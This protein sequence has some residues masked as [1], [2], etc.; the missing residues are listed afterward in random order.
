MRVG[1]IDADLI[2][3]KKHRF[4]NLV[5]EKI[6]AYWKEKG[7]EVELKLDYEDLDSYDH[8]Y[9]SKVFTDTPFPKNI[10]ETDQI[11][12]GGTGFYF[13][14]APNLPDEIE[15]HMPDYH[16]YDEW[17]NKQIESGKKRNDF[18]YYLDYSIGFTSRGCFR[19]CEFCVNR[20]YKKV[21]LHSPLR[22]F[23]DLSR[24][25]ICLLDDNILGSPHW[26]EIF[27]ELQAT[28]K[29]FQYKQGMDERLLTDE[30][31]EVLFKS[32][33]DG[34]YI[35]AFDNVADYELI[36]KKLQLLRKYT[37]KIPKFYVFCGFDREDKWNDE[38]WKQDLWDLWKR[39]E[40]LMKYLCLPYI[41]RFN[42]Y[43]ESPYK[44]TYINLAAW[45]NQPSAFKKKSYR[46]FVEY[47]QSRHQ[48]ECSET[49]YLKQIERD[50]PELAERYFDMKFMD[51]V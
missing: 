31:C 36:E 17:A 7:A 32:K 43:E 13:D 4:P 45:C 5:S 24:K 16:L 20:N 35:F 44:G 38:F 26:R 30:K 41:M 6:S 12:M 14:K 39:I 37:D 8:V 23:L 34:D 33:Y 50:M 21:D 48:K 1:I 19:Q 25:K 3:R 11:H 27:E 18:R 22:E 9:I 28:G 51:F 40:L 2:G 10:V 49:R 46:E 29:P 42:R 47:Q 15:H